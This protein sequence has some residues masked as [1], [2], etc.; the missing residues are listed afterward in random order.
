MGAVACPPEKRG[1]GCSQ[2]GLK[3]FSGL[4]SQT[5]FPLRAYPAGRQ[6]TS[7]RLGIE[8][9]NEPS[10]RRSGATYQPNSEAKGGE[11]PAHSPLDRAGETGSPVRRGFGAPP[12]LD[13]PGPSPVY[14]RGSGEVET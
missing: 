5:P 7:W 4:L 14:A 11:R 10:L 13:G 6:K 2:S 12:F 1:P 8:T 3:D 9:G